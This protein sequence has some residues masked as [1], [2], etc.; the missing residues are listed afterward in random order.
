MEKV[1]ARGSRAVV[2]A[3]SEERVEHLN[4]LL[5]TYDDRGFLPHGSARDG[6]AAEQPVYLTTE[7]ENPNAATVLVL[8]SRLFHRLTDHWTLL[9][10]SLDATARRFALTGA[11][12]SGLPAAVLQKPVDEL[13]S[14]PVVT[15]PDD[16]SLRTGLQVFTEHAFSSLPLVDA[17]GKLVPFGASEWDG[18]LIPG[19]PTFVTGIGS[20]TTYP[21][22]KPA[23]FIVASEYDGVDMVT[24]VSGDCRTPSL[25]R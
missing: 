15:L 9:R 13:M 11:A 14:Q 22:Y 3:G 20:G 19:A 25:A 16:A 17:D 2:V 8:D 24:V 10:R 18:S 6:F 4:A 1:L 21:D 7:E 5:W 23:P 12:P